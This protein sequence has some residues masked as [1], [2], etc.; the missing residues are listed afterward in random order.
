[1]YKWI[2]L[3]LGYLIL[4]FFGGLL[5]L[6]V[7]SIFDRIQSLGLSG[8]NPL[9]AGARRAIFME[10]LF[11]LK[12][13]LAKA[14]GHISQ[15][16]IDHVET[17]IQQNG[18][19][20]EHRQEAIRQF[21]RGSDPSFNIDDTLSHFMTHCGHTFNLRQML[22]I[23][24]IVMALAD[25]KVDEAE[26][27]L[28]QQ[29][30]NRLGFTPAQY[31]QIFSMVMGQSRFGGSGHSTASNS[32]SSLADAYQALGVSQDNT[33]QEIKRAYRKLM[34]EYHPDKLMGQGVPEDMIKVATEKAKE[35][36]LAYDLI[37]KQ[38]GIK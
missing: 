6:F 32:Q 27:A 13:K 23:Y 21:K 28:L 35:I 14:D 22:L 31:Q 33:D 17:F 8:A 25:G 10:T 7:G 26:H 4:G 11:V 3:A 15:D 38:R 18:M 12:G 5:G 34:S 30:A 16:E 20:S 29:V 24:L 2:G 1:M 36:Q 9:T 37:K 19:T